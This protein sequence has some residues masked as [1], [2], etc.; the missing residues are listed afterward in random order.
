MQIP[1]SEGPPQPSHLTVPLPDS[2]S[3]PIPT[4]PSTE[5]S[6]MLGI[7][8]G[9]SSR[10][11]KHLS[12]MC[13]KG[14]IWADKLHSCPLIH[15][16]TW[17][18]FSLQLLPGMLWGLLTVIL[19]LRELFKATRSMY[20]KCLPLLGIQHHIELP[21]RTLPEAY[22]GVGFP[23][24]A[25]LSLS[26]TLQLIQCIWG[27]NDAASVS[28]FMG[29]KSFL[30]D[31]GMYGN[32]LGYDYQRFSGLVMDNRWFKKHLRAVAQF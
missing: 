6:L 4:L 13:L 18:I 17:T 26:S 22:Q 20:F 27:F 14:H 32:S 7:R 25:L 8:F 12:E 31:L 9:P 2:L 29:Y 15:S 19:S 30:M 1:R 21:W 10:R 23:N 24:F 28:L 5:A 3:A 11:S 16:K